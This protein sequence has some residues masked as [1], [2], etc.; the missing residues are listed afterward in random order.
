LSGDASVASYE[1]NRCAG[2][3]KN[4]FTAQRYKI[5]IEPQNITRYAEIMG[6][7]C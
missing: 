7:Y 5:R 4:E 1:K 6:R 3:L 2:S